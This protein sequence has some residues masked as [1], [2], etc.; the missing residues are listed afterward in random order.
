MIHLPPNLFCQILLHFIQ[1]G[2]IHLTM[3][4]ETCYKNFSTILLRVLHA[5]YHQFEVK[6][7]ILFFN[8][9]FTKPSYMARIICNPNFVAFTRTDFLRASFKHL[10]FNHGY[11]DT[12]IILCQMIISFYLEFNFNFIQVH[13]INSTS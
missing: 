8:Y 4:N 2:L 10:E 3:E 1:S 7:E 9:F 5:R 12:A 11:P 13:F 6:F